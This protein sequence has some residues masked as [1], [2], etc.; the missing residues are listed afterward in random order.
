VLAGTST[1]I[2]NTILQGHNTTA[3]V[4]YDIFWD[5]L[6]FGSS[7]ATVSAPASLALA[8]LGLLALGATRRRAA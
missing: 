3:G 8:G 6:S 7:T 5:N 1:R 2:G 4:S